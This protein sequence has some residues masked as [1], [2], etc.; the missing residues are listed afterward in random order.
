[1]HKLGNVSYELRD[2]AKLG[3]E[4]SAKYDWFQGWEIYRLCEK[5]LL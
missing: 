3:Y 1:M 5:R 4:S 2:H